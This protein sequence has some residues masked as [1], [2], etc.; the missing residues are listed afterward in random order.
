MKNGPKVL[1]FDIETAPILAN[2]WDLWKQNVSI[3][4][5]EKDWHVLS[6]AAKWLDKKRVIYR[7]QRNN[8]K[9][10]DDK[11]LLEEIWELLDEADIVITHNGDGFDI[12]KLNARFILNGLQPPSSFKSID[13]CRIAKKVFGFTS[14]KLEYLTGKLCKKYKKLKHKKF[15]G[16]EL[17][18]ECLKGNKSAWKEMEKYN[19]FDVLSLEE[20]YHKLIPWDSSINFNWYTDNNEHVCK[21]GSKD[22][23]KRGFAYTA[24]SKFRR[25]RCKK[26]GAEV[27]D[28]VNLFS[29]EKRASLKTKIR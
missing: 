11:E 22:L 23:V 20:L 13:T 19:K 10:E 12:P 25:Y 17:W 1:I 14:N 5:I 8:K 6:F 9:V 3:N 29:R 2:V 28:T 24:K 7:D 26:C 4:Q 27:R 21:C 15:P 18:T 16:Q